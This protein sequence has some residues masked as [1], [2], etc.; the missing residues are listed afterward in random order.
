M[1]AL[2]GLRPKCGSAKEAKVEGNDREQRSRRDALADLEARIDAA[3]EEVRPKVK[4]AM[5]ELDARVDAAVADLRPRVESAME[6]V[7]PRVDRFLADIQPRLDSALQRMQAKIA[8]LRTD[9][10]ARA[11]RGEK[12]EPA[13]ALPPSGGT[14]AEPGEAPGAPDASGVEEAPEAVQWGMSRV[15]VARRT[16]GGLGPGSAGTSGPGVRR[17][18]P[19]RPVSR[20]VRSPDVPV[21]DRG[22]RL[23]LLP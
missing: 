23:R 20:W 22:D 2:R 3:I 18:R 7:R 14:R 5:E 12:S 8:E 19:V 17:E 9:L 10:E 16:R 21:A 1:G 6:D 13:G 11:G 15:G 4:R